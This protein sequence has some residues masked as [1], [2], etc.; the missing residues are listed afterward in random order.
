MLFGSEILEIA[1]SIAFIYLLMSLIASSFSEWVAQL[2]AMRAST[3][4]EGIRSLL[5]DPKGRSL[6]RAFYSHPL[7][8]TLAKQTQLDFVCGRR[9]RPSYIPSQ[10]FATTLLDLLVPVDKDAGP[11]SIQQIK[12]AISTLQD[13]HLK[14]ALLIQLENAEDD[15]STLRQN[16]ETWFEN[17]MD[18]VSGWYKRKSQGIIILFAS[19]FVICL[20]VDT[21]TIAESLIRDRAL[22][23]YIVTTAEQRLQNEADVS[24]MQETFDKVQ[25]NL[26]SLR[27]LS[28][29]IG[30]V[31]PSGI[32]EDVTLPEKTIVHLK[33]P[34]EIP[35][36]IQ[37]V[38]RK[39]L[40]LFIT[41]AATSLGAPFWFN[42]LNQLNVLRLTGPK[43]SK[44]TD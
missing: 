10:T 2:F 43:P 44:E 24:V 6:A 39:I 30:W 14:R 12:E 5:Y 26:K 25:L 18:R 20:N 19:V 28:L 29:P 15:L 42:T 11:K 35:T 1:L 9:G 41:I 33:D 8:E 38:L 13:P 23:A 27:L 32:K 4:E 3:L 36:T 7:I 17:S 40:G 22:R 34:R 31:Y 16:F 37:G 21:L